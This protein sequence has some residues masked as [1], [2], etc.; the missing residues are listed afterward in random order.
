MRSKKRIT[1]LDV[2][3]L[4]GV[5]TAAVSYV[6]NN[7]PR[8]T[9][10][11]MR[12]RVMRAIRELDYHP[13]VLARGL[14]VQ[15]TNIIG[16]IAYDYLSTKVF[17][18]FYNAT[19][20]TSLTMRLKSLSHYVLVYPMD[21]GQDLG[22]LEI[23]LRSGLLDGVVVRLVEDSPATDALLEMITATCVPCVCIEQPGAPRFGFSAV[24]YD[25]QGGAFEATSYLIAQGHRRIGYI[26]GDMRYLTARTRLAG[27]QRALVHHGVAYDE[28][29]VCGNSWLPSAA[30][31]CVAQMME[32]DSPP[33]AI[34]AASDSL[35]FS[36][37]EELRRQGRRVPEDVAVVGFDDIE[38]A[39]ESIP[40]LTTVHIPLVEIGQRAVDLLID[41]IQ[42]E[43]HISAARL[44]VLPVEFVQ[45][46]TA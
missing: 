17:T 36:V 12:E 45:R 14:R 27:Y 3:K 13:S 10:P 23:L 24:S 25:D 40:P 35:V 32:L 39:T 30:R 29:L 11:E 18:S 8:P 9:S 22:D 38:L 6:I 16:F 20:L 1:H 4:A 21:I 26:C 44:E 34:F 7:G 33:T 2:A 28:K 31:A 37:I 43:D 41:L 15:Q 42:T 5:S 46:G 19:I